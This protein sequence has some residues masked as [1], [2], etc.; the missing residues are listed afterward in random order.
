[1]IQ[2]SPNDTLRGKKV[3]LKTQLTDANRDLAAEA[4]RQRANGKFK[5]VWEKDGRIL[6][7]EGDKTPVIELHSMRQ[8]MEIVIPTPYNDVNTI[9]SEDEDAMEIQETQH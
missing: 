2:L 7:R 4:R 3:F 1:M 5:Y 8:L 9:D 6:A